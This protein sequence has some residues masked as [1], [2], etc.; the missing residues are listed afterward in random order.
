MVGQLK[1]EKIGK[2]YKYY[3]E[4]S[5]TSIA[6]VN[7]WSIKIRK[8]SENEC[9]LRPPQYGAIGAIQAHWSIC[10][11]PATVVMPTGT[12]K[13]ETMILTIVSEQVIK[14]IIVVP[15]SLLREQT[16]RKLHTFGI[17]KDIGVVGKSS[18][19]PNIVLL[20]SVPKS[21]DEW[22][23]LL[24]N[25]NVIVTTMT[26]ASKLQDDQCDKLLAFAD[27]LI[28][29]EAHHIMAK[30][31]MKFRERF[32]EKRILQFTATPFRNDGKKIDGR[33]IY[34]YPL[35]K[36]Q[37]EGYFQ[38][39]NF[40]P[41]HE[42]NK[43]KGD[44]SIA[45]KAIE[46]LNKDIAE[47]KD[48][49]ILVRTTKIERAEDLYENIYKKYYSKYNPVLITSRSTAQERRDGIDALKSLNSRILVCVDMF[50]EGID[51]PNLKIA[52]IHDKYQ[53]LPI[54]IQFVGRFARTQSGLGDASVVT[55]IADENLKESISNL[56][57][58][59]S[60]WNSLLANM[61]EKAI[62]R[63]VSLQELER[64]FRGNGIDGI[65]IRQLRPK[66]SMQAFKV[67]N[68]PRWN[69][70]KKVFKEENC[71][72]YFNAEKN[73]LIIIE[74]SETNLAW[75]EYRDIS[76]LNWELHLLYYNK[77]KGVVFINSSVK[78]N[79]GI[80]A[81]AIFPEA[82]RIR[83]ECIF[84]CLDGINRL[85]L[86]TVGLNS[87]INGPIRYRMFAGI[88]IAEGITEAQKS[89][90]TK[91][92]IFGIGYNG[93][94]K[95]SIGCSY[96]GTVWS[97]WVESVAFWMEWCDQ[98]IDKIT[99]TSIDVEKL[100]QGVLIPQE[101]S[102]LPNVKP[103][104]IDWPI[105]LDLCND[106]NVF[107]STRFHNESLYNSSIKLAEKDIDDG[108]CFRIETEDFYEELEMTINKKGFFFKHVSGDVI[109]L[110]QKKKEL[111]LSDFFAE[112][113]PR[114]KFVDQSTLEGNLYVTLQTKSPIRFPDIN[115]IRWN[116][117]EKGVN[118]KVESQGLSKKT[119]SIQY[120]L[121][122]E[123]KA[124]NKYT[125][126][127]DD[128][129][130]GEIADV[131]AIRIEEDSVLFE[132]YHC[133]YSHE[134]QPGAR[135]SD[136]YEVCGQAEKS[137]EWKQDMIKVVERMLKRE[138]QRISNERPTRFE[139][140]DCEILEEIKNRLKF[141]SSSLKIYIVQP[142]V[143]GDA[144]TQDMN[145]VLMA[146]KVYLQETYGVDLRLICS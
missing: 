116:W 143:D 129:N 55:N 85:M 133:K 88:D 69:N 11:E 132:F 121:I 5:L 7:S 24:D 62:G 4:V 111:I 81:N 28:V 99:D 57:A 70:W 19:S 80:I 91:S 18:I 120:C 78:G 134:E 9:G 72:Y 125:V 27:L 66:V 122:E 25:C 50:G 112:N 137:V 97:R 53:S 124:S 96:K 117:K 115:V 47:K 139:L 1:K 145:Q 65:S 95:V 106:S 68:K 126:I 123:L 84:R 107:L 103:Y 130:S 77:E 34:N 33:I 109:T 93:K 76:N 29:D 54:T 23:K 73:V 13:T 45:E 42:F 39:I 64:G 37:Q 8:K 146:S 74:A 108:I 114:I 31:W 43:Y 67:N 101:I 79:S 131:V 61:S 102:E 6:I 59:D 110:H 49:L 82:E 87:A 135:V 26:L 35:H 75:S 44:L 38:K 15:S 140:G 32:R 52:A 90:S 142:G 22:K 60:D 86:G 89:T 83:G 128:D 118:I 119:E 98:I 71:K 2:N 138:K 127:F 20:K 94:G 141:Y 100:L 14:T 104:R 63:E 105:E 12:G 17:L 58:Q 136:L 36:A 113:P 40:Y 51:I 48:H 41:I 46:C 3:H 16:V 30:T 21:E 56:Y 10:S 92:N 144:I